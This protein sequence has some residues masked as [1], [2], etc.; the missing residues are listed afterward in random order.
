M[1]NSKLFLISKYKKILLFCLVLIPF[2]ESSAQTTILTSA[3]PGWNMLS[4][5]A[6]GEFDTL[7]LPL[8]RAGNLLLVEADVDGQRGNFILDTGAP[9]LVLN[10]TYFRQN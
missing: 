8:K 3:S 7:K 10:T 4:S 1:I 2:L 6:K 5:E 9:G